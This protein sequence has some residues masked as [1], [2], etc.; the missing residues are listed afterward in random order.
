MAASESL[1]GVIVLGGSGA[2]GGAICR[3]LVADGARV[4]FTYFKNADAAAAL[5]RELPGSIAKRVDLESV[6]EL[7]RT[8]TELRADLGGVCGLVHAATLTS[9][10]RDPK[11]EKLDEADEASFDRL[12]AVNVRSAYFACRE[13]ARDFRGNIVL[14]GSL[15][16][17]KSL[18]SPVAY[19]ASKGA[20]VAM[21]RALSKELGSRGVRVNV[22]APG[23]LE[24]G[25]SELVPAELR[26]EYLKHCG[27]KRFGK[28][29]EVA[30]LVSYLTLFNTYV[31]GQ[32][33]V[34]DGAL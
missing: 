9:A 31:T 3:A 21:A 20:L 19:A 7:T 23:V 27:L 16:G 8:L 30:R 33:L 22:V 28:V 14:L 6:A 18:P 2:V 24:R 4:G 29:E 1:P 17:A 32:T 34:V 26:A 12:F 11:F 13:F 10:A 5:E 15:D 25:S